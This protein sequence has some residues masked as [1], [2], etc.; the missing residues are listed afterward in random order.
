MNVNR[1]LG[2]YFNGKV[3]DNAISL[4]VEYG[5]EISAIK[6]DIEKL[7]E[8]KKE[9]INETHSLLVEQQ[10][11]IKI[12]KAEVDD[13]NKKAQVLISNAE[14]KS[15]EVAIAHEDA[16]TTK[17]ALDSHR[18]TLESQHKEKTKHLNDLESSLQ[19]RSILLDIKESGL[20][21]DEE[22]LKKTADE[23]SSKSKILS[24]RESTIARLESEIG[25]KEADI[26]QKTSELLDKEKALATK[27]EEINALV[28]K[29]KREDAKLKQHADA[30]E[31]L[32][33]KLQE[34]REQLFQDRLIHKAAVTDLKER[35]QKLKIDEDNIRVEA[36]KVETMRRAI[37]KEMEK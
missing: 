29:H 1:V 33:V 3:P 34:D 37:L 4:V 8:K 22:F 30:V 13:K 16:R 14:Q 17:I 19:K 12:L 25:S 10:E 21:H 9:L 5:K 15:K 35:Q 6:E 20:K 7:K 26:S 23:Q 24:L 31:V 18:N 36:E 32:S 28:E 2:G 27:S 11:K